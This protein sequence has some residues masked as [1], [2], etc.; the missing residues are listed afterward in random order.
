MCEPLPAHNYMLA[1]ADCV[2]LE[3][4]QY[5]MT[6]PSMLARLFPFGV[7]ATSCLQRTPL[8]QTLPA[9]TQP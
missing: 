7:G 6:S 3:L 1:V 8:G 2:A 5:V 9:L 4:M